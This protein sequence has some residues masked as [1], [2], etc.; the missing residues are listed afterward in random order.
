MTLAP[1]PFRSAT[2]GKRHSA[3]TVLNDRG[4]VHLMHRTRSRST[5]LITGYDEARAS[6]TD[7]RL[8]KGG[9]GANIFGHRLDPALLAATRT[10]ML[11]SDPP[12][13]TRLRKL[14]S[15]AFTMRRIDLLAPR[16]QQV[17]D[18]LLDALVDVESADLVTTFAYPLPMTVICDLLGIPEERRADFRTWSAQIIDPAVVGFEVFAEAATDLVGYVRE[19]I[20]TKRAQPADDLL[21]AVIAVRDGSDQLSE[22]EL[23]SLVILLLVA[24]HETTVNFIANATFALL[25]HPEQLAVLRAEPAR[26]PA[27]VEELLRFDGPL[28][29][30]TQRVATETF[31]LG[32]VTI[33]AGDVVLT[34]LLAANRDTSHLPG[35]DVLDVTRTPTP[36][37]AF[38]HGIHHC[39]GA[40]LA[41]LEA[42]IAL[43]SLITRFPDLRLATPADDLPV[44]DAVLINALTALQVATRPAPAS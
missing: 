24:G 23:T 2:H 16:I 40:P 25:T 35:A 38:G 22:D 3:Y 27:A 15:G 26:I 9:G 42:R 14:V 12:N 29:I 6:L 31:E 30:A 41:R 4:P 43:S 37:L 17:V 8:V 1:D 34:G 32:G 20:A 44:G 7:P 19:L 13:H 21:S 33:S 11:S 39:L 28:Q 5:W 18:G 36:H 10:E